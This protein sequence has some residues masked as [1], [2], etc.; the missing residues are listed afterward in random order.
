MKKSNRVKCDKAKTVG[1]VSKHRKLRKVIRAIFVFV[2]LMMVSFVVFYLV[3]RLLPQKGYATAE[4][5][6]FRNMSIYSSS[7]ELSSKNPK[8][9]NL[10]LVSLSPKHGDDYLHL[11]LGAEYVD[12]IIV[13]GNVVYS[14]SGN[15]SISNDTTISVQVPQIATPVFSSGSP[16]EFSVLVYDRKALLRYVNLS[17]VDQPILEV[18]ST[19]ESRN[20]QVGQVYFWTNGAI[21]TYASEKMFASPD[22]AV[23]APLKIIIGDNAYTSYMDIKIVPRGDFFPHIVSNCSRLRFFPSR[24]YFDNQNTKMSQDEY[25]WKWNLYNC[26]NILLFG[27]GE[28]ALW[29]TSVPATRSF[30]NQILKIRTAG[31]SSATIDKWNSSLKTGE[32]PL[33]ARGLLYELSGG[34]GGGE[35]ISTEIELSNQEAKNHFSAS[36]TASAYE[37]SGFS[38][39]TTFSSWLN[40]NLG[41][42]SLSIITSLLGVF[43]SLYLKQS[44]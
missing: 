17:S 10:S 1:A 6:S 5:S 39:F 14:S 32:Q 13:D 42:V 22:V 3:F 11:F 34:L 31:L 8:S 23:V 25:D 44:G 21:E 24:G 29:Q 7:I 2:L 35:S 41:V 9:E 30:S 40:N 43:L 28:G 16:I 38:L 18:G 4:S 19:K 26:T 37:I 27:E 15:H 36:G 20:S 33:A 12:K